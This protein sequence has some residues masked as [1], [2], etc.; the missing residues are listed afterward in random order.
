MAHSVTP[1]VR[2]VHRRMRENDGYFDVIPM[3]Q[4][5]ED[6]TAQRKVAL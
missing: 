1:V 4:W 3:P 6:L 2:E 5:V